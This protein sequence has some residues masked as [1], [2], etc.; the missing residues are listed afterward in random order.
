M[1]CIDHY[2]VDGIEYLLD[3]AT[4][5]LKAKPLVYGATTSMLPEDA[6]RIEQTIHKEPWTVGRRVV[7]N[8][9]SNTISLFNDG[10]SDS[11]FPGT[12]AVPLYYQGISIIPHHFCDGGGPLLK[13]TELSTSFTETTLDG[14]T[15]AQI[16]QIPEGVYHEQFQTEIARMSGI[17]N[18]N[19][20]CDFMCFFNSLF[21][22]LPWSNMSLTA[23]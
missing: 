21:F 13:P 23:I 16:R 7:I 3:R 14:L 1:S 4:R 15:D 20:L 12:A 19:P 8:R 6:D 22:L 5:G 2:I 11:S 10:D 18:G 9:E 17:S